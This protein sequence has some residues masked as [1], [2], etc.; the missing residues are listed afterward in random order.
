MG[1]GTHVSIL[2]VMHAKLK[3][4]ADKEHRTMRTILTRIIE[5]EHKKVFK[6]GK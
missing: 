1:N 4:I 3:E 2:K 5:A 6:D